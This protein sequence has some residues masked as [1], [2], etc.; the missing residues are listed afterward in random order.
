MNTPLKA[1]LLAG[2]VTD[3]F[4]RWLCLVVTTMTEAVVMGLGDH[5]GKY[6]YHPDPRRPR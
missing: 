1:L 6:R 5:D 3:R 4:V 2:D